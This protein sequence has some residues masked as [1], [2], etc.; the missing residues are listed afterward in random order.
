MPKYSPPYS[1][2]SNVR[3]QPL[4][5]TLL[6]HQRDMVDPPGEKNNDLWAEQIAAASYLK[7]GCTATDFREME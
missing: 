4:N 5:R 2:K 3:T 1:S 7:T 6:Y